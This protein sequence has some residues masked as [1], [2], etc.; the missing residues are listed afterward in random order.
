MAITLSDEGIISFITSELDE[1][2]LR[3][4]IIYWN[5]EPYQEEDRIQIG[6][7]L[8]TIPF[9]GYLVFIDLVPKANWGH[10]CLYYFIRSDGDRF[11]IRKETFPPVFGEFP[12]S[13]AVLMRYGENPPHERYFQVY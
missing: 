5:R 1:G 6:R 8:F 4:S 7:K 10:P 12:Q 13:W 2:I 3:S 11:I 9:H